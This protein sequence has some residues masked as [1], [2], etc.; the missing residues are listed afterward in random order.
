M[1]DNATSAR[2][3]K[4]I[5]SR[6]VA[7]L[8]DLA[9]LVTP[10]PWTAEALCAQTD[11]EAFFPEKGGS[12]RQAKSVCA[13]CPV[14]DECL[15]YALDRDERFGIWGGTSE[16]ERR[17]IRKGEPPRPERVRWTK[18]EDDRLRELAADQSLSNVAIAKLLERPIK[19]VH[20][21]RTYLGIAPS[22]WRG[23]TAPAD[24]Q[25]AA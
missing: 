10:E 23:R 4:I 7:T 19:S 17:R 8:D 21:R 24:R 3:N 13:A 25:M 20:K 12:T 18:A 22:L 9:A 1:N 15:R 11:P 2:A 16:R 14:I 5:R 6:T